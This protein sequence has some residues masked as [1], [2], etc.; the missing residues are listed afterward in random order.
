MPTNLKQSPNLTFKIL[1]FRT[2]SRPQKQNADPYKITLMFRIKHQIWYT[3]PTPTKELAI[4]IYVTLLNSSCLVE[5]GIPPA[6][7]L[8]IC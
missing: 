5:V 6:H 7:P 8:T 1:L 4:Y 3:P 2:I